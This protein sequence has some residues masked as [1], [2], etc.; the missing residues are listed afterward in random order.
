MWLKIRTFSRAT[1]SIPHV[2]SA[3]T[4]ASS[5]K[6][7]IIASTLNSTFCLTTIYGTV[8]PA[9]YGYLDKVAQPAQYAQV[10]GAM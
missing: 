8:H 7:S 1:H 6:V 5:S 4:Q 3:E 9:K 10:D 2:W